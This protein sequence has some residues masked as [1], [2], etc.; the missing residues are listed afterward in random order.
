MTHLEYLRSLESWRRWSVKYLAHPRGKPEWVY[1][2]DGTSDGWAIQSHLC[3]AAVYAV[4]AADPDL[5]EARAGA[6]REAVRDTALAMFR[7]AADTVQG[8]PGACTDG[9]QWLRPLG[10]IRYVHGL[11][12]LEPCLTDEDRTRV[13]R[14]FA[15]HAERLCAPDVVIRAG[16]FGSNAPESNYW[17]AFLLLEAAHRFPEHP[18]RAQWLERSTAFFLNSL[19]VPADARSD[20]IYAGRPLRAW[21]VGANLTEH[22][23][24]NHHSYI[25]VGYKVIVLS[26]VAM[27]YFAMRDRG[28]DAPPEAFLHVADLWRV[29]RLCTFEDGR[30]LRI[31]G[32]TRARYC[33]CQDYALPAWLGM[34]AKY[35][36]PDGA[37]LEAGWA[38]LVAAEQAHNGDGS[39]LSERLAALER[40]SPFYY[41]RLE[42]DRAVT[43]S[44]AA[45]WRRRFPDV[46][47]PRREPTPAPA[48]ARGSWADPVLGGVVCRGKHRI[49][50]WRWRHSPGGMCLPAGRS[51]MA[52]WGDRY[53]ASL[54]G[55]VSGTGDINNYLPDADKGPGKPSTAFLRRLGDAGFVTAGEVL[56]ESLNPQGEGESGKLILTRRNAVFALPDDRTMIGFQLA[57]AR[58]DGFIRR[59]CAPGLLVP[60]D[61]FNGD[62]RRIRFEGGS[63]L[64]RSRPGRDALI[65]TGSAWAAVDNSLALVALYGGSTVRI[66]RTAAR[67]MAVNGKPALTSL[68]VET[69]CTVFDASIR[70]VTEGDVVLDAGFVVLAGPRIAE[71]ARTLRPARLDDGRGFVRAARVRDA[72][73]GEWLAA[74]NLGAEPAE[75]AFPLAGV[76]I[77]EDAVSG[78]AHPVTGGR[79]AWRLEPL[80]PVLARLRV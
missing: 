38:G 15:A 49:A 59:L 46:L 31:G 77:A 36:D 47:P 48:L 30:L 65:E 55:Q 79:L 60:N 1:Y 9:K 76:S 37:G 40:A 21:H 22:F 39:Y 68:Y 56:Q 45:W 69:L 73:G 54:L 41:A 78:A 35:N 11:N 71:A 43:A 42:S 4:L 8:G 19:S 75:A 13:R 14:L 25:N 72:A 6:S 70:H 34:M 2:N 10:V 66:A 50:S 52:E 26:Q 53:Y 74:A 5:D 51:D 18:N 29:V 44:M 27:A 61:I 17:N 58:M 7:F 67:Q 16:I 80:K 33:Y 20:E 62:A 23:G 28:L 63:Q 24:M 12:A 57:L 64:L 3:A 32:D